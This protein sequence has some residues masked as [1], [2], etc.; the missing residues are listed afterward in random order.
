MLTAKVDKL[1]ISENNPVTKNLHIPRYTFEHTP[2][3][4]LAGVTL[5]YISNEISYVIRKESSDYEF[6]HSWIYF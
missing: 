5:M 6:I 3:E 2:T 1:C 4:S